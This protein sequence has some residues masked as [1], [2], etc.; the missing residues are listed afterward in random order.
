MLIDILIVLFFVFFSHLHETAL[1]AEK[2]KI[3]ILPF[4][5]KYVPLHV[6]SWSHSVNPQ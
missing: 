5:N 6:V 2:K 4:T 3:T 1:A